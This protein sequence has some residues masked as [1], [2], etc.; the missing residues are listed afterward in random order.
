MIGAEEEEIA[1]GIVS[2]STRKASC[3]SSIQAS[4]AHRLTEPR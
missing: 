1:E 3:T 2:D 4:G